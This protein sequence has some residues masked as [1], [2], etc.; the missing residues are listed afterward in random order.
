VIDIAKC[1]LT[2]IIYKIVTVFQCMKNGTLCDTLWCL[3]WSI[4]NLIMSQYWTCMLNWLQL[5][6]LWSKWKKKNANAR[7]SFTRTLLVHWIKF[8]SSAAQDDK[9]E[10][11]LKL[12]KI[13][14]HF[15]VWMN[16]VYSKRLRL[17]YRK[18]CFFL[19]EWWVLFSTSHDLKTAKLLWKKPFKYIL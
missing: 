10:K 11:G 2:L 7:V 12:E 19:I 17:I 5:V 13:G 8:L 15:Q 1:P 9:D 16:T 3:L 4:V 14:P 18:C 6:I